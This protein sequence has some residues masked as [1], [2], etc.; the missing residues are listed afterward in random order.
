MRRA[1]DEGSVTV[2]TLGLVAVLLA[3]LATVASATHVQLQRARLAH[4][5]DEV[6]L[7]AADAIDLDVYYSA[8]AASSPLLD[9]DRVAAE[10]AEHLP[11]SATRN[12]VTDAVLVRA[13]SPDGVT[14][15]VTVALRSPV[16]FGAEWLP[17]RVDLAASASARAS[18]P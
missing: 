5:A 8:G 2:L 13:S 1:H 3:A 7:A 16:L 14:A 12:G 17:G 4:V 11:L 6:A 15:E 10:A 9:P 18:V